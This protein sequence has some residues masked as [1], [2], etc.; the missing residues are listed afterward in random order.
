M[1]NKILVLIA[2]L[3]AA[4]AVNAAPVALSANATYHT[5]YFDKGLVAFEDVAVAGA[6]LEVYNFVAGVNTFNTLKDTATG[7]YTAS[8]GLFKR[9]DLSLGYKFTSPLANLTLGGTYKNF[10]KSVSNLSSNTE[11]FALLNGTFFGT[12][13]TWDA[14]YR[15]DLKNRTNN[16][17][18]NL[19]L[20]F[21]FQHLK[22]VPALGYGFNDLGAD[23][24]AQYKNAKQ[25][26][27]VGIG[28]GYYTKYATLNVD[29]S[30][31][32]DGLITAGNTTNSLSAGLSVK[33]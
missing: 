28:L 7:K 8:A 26:A 25:Y 33:F 32:R 23:T 21:G 20:P 11:P 2:A 3:I 19:R 17:E 15:N 14:R 24:I 6:T 9:T 5:K 12:R 10:S 1:K 22:L 13:A 30:Q 16:T 29:F 31:L 27:V 18:A 4:V